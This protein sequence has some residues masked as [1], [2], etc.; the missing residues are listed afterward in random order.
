MTAGAG[1]RVAIEYN[2][3]DGMAVECLGG[4]AVG[5][6]EAERLSVLSVGKYLGEV[7]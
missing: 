7:T 3:W 2:W 1:W 5:E 4:A 6:D